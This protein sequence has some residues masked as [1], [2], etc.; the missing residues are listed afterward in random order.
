MKLSV[1]IPVYN[2]VEYLPESLNR[3]LAALP[4]VEKEIIVVDDGS[5]DGSREWIASVI[6]EGPRPACAGAGAPVLL[7]TIPDNDAGAVST[8]RSILHERNMGKGAALRTGLGQAS[9]DVIVIHD[10]DLEYDP[11]DWKRFWGL[12]EKGHAD[13]VYGSRFHGEP[14]RCLYYHHYLA[15]KLISLIFSI[16]YNQILSDIEVCYKMFNR[17]V[18]KVLTLRRNDFGFEIEFSANV[19]RASRLRIYETGISYYGRS[20]DQG[21]KINWKDG[22]KAIFYLF[23]HRFA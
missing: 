5:L 17:E 16:L 13:V 11:A 19:A 10:A 3:V 23:W 8:V 14:H 4:G 22:V 1:V 18:L 2:E 9:G 20:Y 12:F 21:K 7:D 15:N 6:G